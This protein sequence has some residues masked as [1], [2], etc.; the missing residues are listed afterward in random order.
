MWMPRETRAASNCST[1]F[2]AAQEGNVLFAKR[3]S[4]GSWWG[5]AGRISV[6]SASE[7]DVCQRLLRERLRDLET[8]RVIPFSTEADAQERISLQNVERTYEAPYPKCLVANSCDWN[9]TRCLALLFFR[10][11]FL[12]L[13][14]M[15]PL[16]P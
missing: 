15:K 12:V 5:S 9:R 7:V 2:T 16:L 11:Q 1:R 3:R 6:Q 8:G 13:D 10:L 4:A 14:L